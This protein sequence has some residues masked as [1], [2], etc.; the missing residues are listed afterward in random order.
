MRSVGSFL[1]DAR[2][3]KKYRR[4]E[5]SEKSR[6]KIHFIRA[7][8]EEKW[9]DLPEFPVVVGFVKNLASLLGVD[10]QQAV[11]LLKRDYPPHETEVNPRPDVA[12][13]F[14]WSPRLTFGVC[15][16]VVTVVGAGYLAFVYA[17][18]VR[19]PSVFVEA[20]SDGEKVIGGELKVVGKVSPGAGVRV[21]DQ[22]AELDEDGHFETEIVVS[23]ATKEV[24]VK[25]VSRSGKEREVRVPIVVEMEPK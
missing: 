9:D 13:G 3:S 10:Q 21:N 8:E 17:R 19:P 23:E 11:A 16:L 14:R 22:P 18:F 1:K 20:P 12:R 2:L 4:L 15:A 6:I 5:L 7:I 24:V 25:A